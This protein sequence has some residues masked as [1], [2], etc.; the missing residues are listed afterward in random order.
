[1][2]ASSKKY[3]PLSV[4]DRSR[5]DT[6][7]TMHARFAENVFDTSNHVPTS[8]PEPTNIPDRQTISDE[9]KL[10]QRAEG[11]TCINYLKAFLVGSVEGDLVYLLI[12]FYG[13]IYIHIYRI[14][15]YTE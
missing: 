14:K 2:S 12:T 9:S 6:E 10:A 5:L 4:Y 13:N 11:Y 7:H 15:L 3:I 1:M 8:N